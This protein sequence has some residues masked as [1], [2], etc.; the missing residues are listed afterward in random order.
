MAPHDRRD[1]AVLVAPR[2]HRRT[3]ASLKSARLAVALPSTDLHGS[4]LRPRNGAGPRCCFAAVCR[5]E[6]GITRVAWLSSNAGVWS[7]GPNALVNWTEAG[8]LGSS[9]SGTIVSPSCAFASGLARERKRLTRRPCRGGRSSAPGRVKTMP[10]L[11]RTTRRARC[12]LEAELSS[13]SSCMPGVAAASAP[14]R[15]SIGRS[16]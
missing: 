16:R 8:V 9:R 11:G 5:S 13:G 10:A 3:P 6:V 14:G 4:A 12:R 1:P 15:C 2:R 7:C